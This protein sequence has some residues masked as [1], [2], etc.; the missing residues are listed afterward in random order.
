MSEVAIANSALA[1]IG[2]FSNGRVTAFTDGT[3]NANFF[4]ERYP[5]LRDALLRDHV[6]TFAKRRVKLARSTRTP[7]FEWAYQYRL[8][9]DYFR[10]L[11][12]SNN[13][14][15]HGNIRYRLESDSVDGRVIMTDAEDVYL[16]YIAK[17]TNTAEMPHDFREALAYRLAAECAIE[18]AQSNTLY[19]RME[20]EARYAIGIAKSTGAIEDYPE[21]RPEGS[22]VTA[23]GGWASRVGW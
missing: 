20:R 11:K 12:A 13:D 16:S 3:R 2:E 8:P 17:V 15:G 7:A 22:W 1:K 23:R 4:A 9:S 5:E 6:W 14:A 10:F 18:F 21:E 19:D